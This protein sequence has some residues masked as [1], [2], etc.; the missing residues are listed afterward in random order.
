MLDASALL[1]RLTL[2]GV[3][4]GDRYAALAS[5][6]E[7][8]LFEEPWYVFNDLHGVV[9]LCGAGR[10]D[11]AR[12]VIERLEQYAVGRDADTGTNRAMTRE[13]GLP[14]ARAIVAFTEGRYVDAITDLSSSRPVF[15]HF[16]GSH[17]QRDL[18]QRTLTEAAIRAGELDLARSLV[19]ERLQDRGS[20]VYGLL[21][22]ARVLEQQGDDTASEQA[23]S[24]AEANRERFAAASAA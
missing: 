24:A 9:A 11:D 16:G 6:W 19:D 4:S 18:L 8:Q 17:A 13:V 12:A 5:A 22:R 2:D 10:L 1:W 20:S 21:A 15:H 7:G 23:R 3:D 14:A